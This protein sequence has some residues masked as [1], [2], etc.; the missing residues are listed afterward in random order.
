MR[1]VNVGLSTKSWVIGDHR[2]AVEELP[3]HDERR[4]KWATL[5]VGTGRTVKEVAR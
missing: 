3:A 4:R 1:C 2:I 5:Q